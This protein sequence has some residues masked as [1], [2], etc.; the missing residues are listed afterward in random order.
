[1]FDQLVAL[2]SADVQF[3]PAVLAVKNAELDLV[4]KHDGCVFRAGLDT[5]TGPCREL[6][7]DL[8]DERCGAGHRCIVPAVNLDG[9]PAAS[10]GYD[11]GVS[12]ESITTH[13]EGL[14]AE[15]HELRRREQSDNADSERLEADRRRLDEIQI[16]LDRCWDLLRQR[17]AL[18]DA[19]ENPNAARERDASTVERY[20]Q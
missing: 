10:D 13:I 19:G 20:L 1:M 11:G 6:I 17:D 3:G 4:V 9:R 18:R 14:V 8:V 7:G 5:D 15:E 12:D 2:D 16:E